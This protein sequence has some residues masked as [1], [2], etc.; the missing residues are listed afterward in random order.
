MKTTL[1]TLLALGLAAPAFAQSNPTVPTV[2]ANG[3][4]IV[5]TAT[6]SADAIPVDLLGSSITVLD[7]AALDQ[8]QTR[9]VSDVLRDVPGVAVS[10]TGA[11]GGFTQVRLRGSEANHT[12]VLVDGIKVSDPFYGEFDFG[13]L[14]ADESAKIEV[15]R[16][17]QS[18]LYGS[19]AIGGVINYITSTGAEAPGIR[20][21]AEGG[22][23]GT[24]SGGARAAGVAGDLDYALTSSYIHTRG[25]PV[26]VG[27]SRDVGSDD[28]GASAKA[29]WTAAPNVKLTG[30]AR[31]S[32]TDAD[33]DDSDNDFTSATYGRTIDSPGVHYRNE[34]F[35]GL[36]RGQW[37]LLDGRFSNVVV[38]QLADTKRDG[39]DV[40]DGSAP[41]PGKPIA[42]TSGDDGHR[43]KG[44]YQGTFRFGTDTIKQSVT[45][46]VDYEHESERTTVSQF[47]AFLGWRHTNNTGIVG[48]YE[49]TANDRLGFGA[50]VRRDLNSRFADSTTWHVQSSYKFDEGTRIHAAGG[51]G[52]K[53]PTFSEL[54]DYYVGR[55]IGN[56][57]L[58]PEKSTGWE[59]GIGQSLLGDHITLDATY[60]DNRLRD[61]ITTVYDA[62][63]VASSVNLPG[64]THQR[65]VELS[66]AAKLDGGWRFD[67]SYTYLHAPQD[68]TVTLDPATF[69][70]GTVS[71][72]AVRRAKS[73]ASASLNWSPPEQPFTV[74]ATV[75]YNGRQNDLF[76]GYFP[77]LL[78]K[79]RSFTLVNLAATYRLTPKIELFARGENLLNRKYQEIY[80]YAAMGRAGYGGVRVAF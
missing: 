73:I 30:V 19:D 52:V 49:L 58:K 41:A 54:F 75:R 64:R 23:F 31:Y 26:A 4:A 61:Q 10:R 74:T 57:N 11:V 40:A 44:S 68:Q 24:F 2:D 22:S 50:S 25:Y 13:T 36:L 21:R 76:Y 7:A 63:F 70:S 9:V 71:A 27:G 79:L 29:T 14:I 37:D 42:R 72:Q 78:E 65:G 16:G 35:Y 46:A 28:V 55:Y 59:A 51:S 45:A 80:S 56:P 1:T 39:Y 15:L 38:G 20:L 48:E 18:S 67:A 33:T 62:N 6:R 47:G 77:P 8:R 34:A 32:Y 60:F 3:D 43:Y 66:A 5:V 12:L 69:A 17:Q 53:A